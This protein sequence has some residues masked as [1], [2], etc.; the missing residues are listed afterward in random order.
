MNTD[1]YKHKLE[2]EKKVLLAELSS[3]GKNIDPE[4]NGWEAIPE[5][6]NEMEADENDLADRFEDYEKN[7]EEV[8]ALDAR[9]KEVVTALKNIDDGTYGICKVCHGR[10][11]EERLNANPAATTCKEHINA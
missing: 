10:I 6:M 1:N 2:E 3:L 8:R 5:K 9:L 7:S 11:E 4:H